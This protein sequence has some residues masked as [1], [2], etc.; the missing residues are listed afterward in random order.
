V[1]D[2][3]MIAR[4]SIN[5]ALKHGRATHVA[6]ELELRSQNLVLRVLDN[7]CGFE[8]AIATNGKRGHFGCAGMRERARKIGATIS[9]QST[10]QRG[11]TVEVLLPLYPQAS[12][13]SPAAHPNGAMPTRDVSPPRN[14]TPAGGGST[15]S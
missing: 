1:H 8:A 12:A 7:G 13:P 2:L 4:E 3:R 15:H 14:V 11:S 5:N 10:L 9:W 6:I